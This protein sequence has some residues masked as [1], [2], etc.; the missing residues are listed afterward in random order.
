MGR[1]V[2]LGIVLA[3]ALAGGAAAAVP[4]KVSLRS[5]DSTSILKR[6]S[7]SVKVAA[8]RRGKV[9]VSAGKLA[10]GRTVKFKRRGAKLVRLRLTAAGRRTIGACGPRRRIPFA[11]DGAR[12]GDCCAG[13]AR[14][15]AASAP[16]ALQ[17]TPSLRA[18]TR[19]PAA[20][21]STRRSACSR[22]PTTISPLKT[23]P[24]PRAAAWT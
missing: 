4:V 6:G 3:L 11:L 8:K 21:H 22:G 16:P 14:A 23:P 19:R 24:P 17:A 13:R 7:L 15:P 9:R 12:L 18:S 5:V 10:R 20:T 1:G 2:V